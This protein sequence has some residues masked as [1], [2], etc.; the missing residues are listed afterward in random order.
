MK[1]KIMILYAKEIATAK[2]VS[3]I[4]Q[5]DT[6]SVNNAVFFSVTFFWKFQGL[7]KNVFTPII[8]FLL[9][10]TYN[11]N[12]DLNQNFIKEFHKFIFF[13]KINFLRYDEI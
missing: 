9:F 11:T 5:N 4:L 13:S 2:D 6:N 12:R 1:I 3:C 7:H 10:L 8:F